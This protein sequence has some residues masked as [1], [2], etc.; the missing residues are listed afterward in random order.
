MSEL[1]SVTKQVSKETHEFGVAIVAVTAKLLELSKDG[2]DW[3][4][5]L[6]LVGMGLGD[7]LPGIDGAEKIAQEF[8]DNPGE[9][10]G[11]VTNLVQDIITEVNKI[12]G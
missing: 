2:W 4:D 8:K 7:V 9:T 10:V 5:A 12:Y 6:E 3:S 1:V 11:A